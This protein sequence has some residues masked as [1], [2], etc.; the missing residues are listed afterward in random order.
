ME[1]QQQKHRIRYMRLNQVCNKALEQSI[2]KLQSW[3]KLVSCYPT[4]ATTED[5]AT[6]LANCQKQ[7]CEFWLELCRRE[8]DEIFGERNVKE[9]L[10]ELDDL[11]F[12]A[13]QNRD[14]HS[15]VKKSEV[16]IDELSPGQL[17]SG[18]LYSSRKSTITELNLR[19]ESL[20]T[21]NQDMQKEIEELN[22]QIS[23]DLQDLEDFYAR[24]LG[25]NLPTDRETLEQGRN[26]MLLELAEG[27]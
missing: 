21:L 16:S 24:Y 20:V 4:Y 19:L 17:I 14:D 1:R 6:N 3:E 26:D 18:N 7:V 5:G 25:T 12:Q 9:K 27:I 11:V 8:F 2:S 23:D 13:K 22:A 10:D 15:G